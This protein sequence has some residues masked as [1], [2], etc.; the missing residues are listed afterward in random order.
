[1]DVTANLTIRKLDEAEWPSAFS[2]VVSL[3]T[4]LDRDEFLRRVRVQQALGYDLTG[5]FRSGDL[6]GVMGA[7]G[8]H[9]LARGAYLHIDDLVV[10]EDCQRQGI[11]AALLRHAEDEARR[12]GMTAVFLDA[13]TDAIPFYE[14]HGYAA[15]TAPS[16]KKAL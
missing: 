6:V 10:R 8:A 9:T 15:H 1:M 4:A 7:R 16:M 13:R 5:A 14:R 3:R 2:I 11:G 12:R